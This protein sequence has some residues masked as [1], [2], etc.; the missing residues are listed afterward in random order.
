MA[1]ACLKEAACQKSVNKLGGNYFKMHA[2]DSANM[3]KHVL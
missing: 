3:S 2:G 1:H